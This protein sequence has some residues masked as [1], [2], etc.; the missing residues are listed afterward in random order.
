MSANTKYAVFQSAG[1]RSRHIIAGAYSRFAIIP[2]LA[3]GVSTNNVVLMG[4]GIGGKPNTVSWVTNEQ[5]A[6]AIL[7]GGDLYE[8]VRFAFNPKGRDGNLRPQQLGLMVVN[9]NTQAQYLMKNGVATII[10]VKSKSY[11]SP[12]NAI[13]LKLEAG[14]T[15]GSK[16]L[17]EKKIDVV[18]TIDNI[19]AVYLTVR[20]IGAGSACTMSNDGTT[21]TTVATGDTAN[22]LSI[23]IAGLSASALAALINANAA[24][25]ATVNNSYSARLVTELDNLT[26]VDIKTATY[27]VRALVQALIETMNDD[28]QYLEA[29]LTGARLVPDNVATYAALTGATNGNYTTTEWTNALTALKTVDVNHVIA[30]KDDSAVIALVS[31]HLADTNS[32][33]GRAERQAICGMDDLAAAQT[34]AMSLNNAALQIAHGIISNYDSAGRL[35]EFDSTMYAAQLGGQKGALEVGASCGFENVN[36]I[37]ARI[38]SNGTLKSAL[39]AGVTC[40]E[41]TPTGIVRTNREISTYQGEDLEMCLPSVL[42]E[43]YYMMRTLRGDI[44]AKFTG[45]KGT[46][47]RTAS[48]DSIFKDRMRGFEDDDQIIIS[49]GSAQPAYWNYTRTTD[50]NVNLMEFSARMV[51]PLEFHFITAKLT[52][53]A[54]VA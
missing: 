17:T 52:I 46:P 38:N 16:K 40:L 36:A 13:Q 6:L 51:A 34:L 42:W 3:G 20:Y 19:D 48:I 29:T 23:T 1:Q 50:G 2:S 30:C 25:Q 4:Y 44:E 41:I 35:V 18:N 47:S 39:E 21:L 12:S 24:Y 45:K 37:S 15:A 8:K 7:E 49:V 22:N 14:T 9:S 54:S 11:G 32:V 43:I 53:R 5:D 26:A 27:S 33:E 31:A 28:S 10:T